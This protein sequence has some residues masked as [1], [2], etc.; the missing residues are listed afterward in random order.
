MFKI[1]H[2]AGLFI[3]QQTQA[4]ASGHSKRWFFLIQYLAKKKSH[5]I[6]EWRFSDLSIRPLCTLNEVDLSVQGRIWLIPST[7]VK[8]MDQTWVKSRFNNS[9]NHLIKLNNGAS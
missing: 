1:K 3:L 9:P 8:F 2:D 5:H 7:G 6:R 4:A